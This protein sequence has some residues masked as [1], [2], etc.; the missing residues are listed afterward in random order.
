M[1]PKSKKTT[2][3][4]GWLRMKK[5]LRL[6]SLNLVQALTLAQCLRGETSFEVKT[7]A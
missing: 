6:P 1:G 4:R 2:T 5:S 3:S 7:A